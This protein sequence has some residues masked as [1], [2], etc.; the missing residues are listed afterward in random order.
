MPM[1]KKNKTK[2]K[3]L[4]QQHKYPG[5]AYATQKTAGGHLLPNTKYPGIN[6]HVP[7]ETYGVCFHVLAIVPQ[8]P[9]PATTKYGA[10]SWA[11]LAYHAARQCRQRG[12]PAGRE[13]YSTK[14]SAAAEAPPRK[15]N[16]QSHR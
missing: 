4:T 6:K 8:L 14:N 10:T 13:V 9:Q 2:N 3:E 12:G 5:A 16:Y 1:P 7:Y 11:A 15:H